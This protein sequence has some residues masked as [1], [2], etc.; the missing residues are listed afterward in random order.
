MQLVLNC[1]FSFS[2]TRSTDQADLCCETMIESIWQSWLPCLFVKILCWYWKDSVGI[3]YSVWTLRFRGA[4]SL[5]EQIAPIGCNR[6]LEA[7]L[8]LKQIGSLLAVRPPNDMGRFHYLHQTLGFSR[9][10]ILRQTPNKGPQITRKNAQWT[11]TIDSMPDFEGEKRCPKSRAA[12]FCPLV[13][14]GSFKTKTYKKSSKQKS[15][16]ISKH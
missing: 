11:C 9:H 6:K 15:S 5:A 16:W 2:E 3:H 7:L 1:L 12:S 10:L 13:S 4:L 14:D 8:V